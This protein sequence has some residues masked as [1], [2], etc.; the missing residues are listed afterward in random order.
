MGRDE[1]VERLMDK[2]LRAIE[3][4]LLASEA[5]REAARDAPLTD[6]DREFLRSVGIRAES[7]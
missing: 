7:C 6:P 2:L 3:A 1:H 5:A 4:S